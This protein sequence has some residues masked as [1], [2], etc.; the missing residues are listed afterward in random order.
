MPVSEQTYELVALEDPEGKWELHCGQLRSK[1]GMTAAH[2]RIG[3]VLGFR[4]QLQLPL[5]AFEV[6]VDA[7]RVRIARVGIEGWSE[8]LM[9]MRGEAVG[10]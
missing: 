6:S 1:P 7:A 8:R 10:Y 9:E 4:L 2:N 5:D 3:R